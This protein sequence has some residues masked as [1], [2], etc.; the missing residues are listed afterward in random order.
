[1]AIVRKSVLGIVAACV[2]QGAAFAQATETEESK[3]INDAF[4]ALMLKDKDGA[5][6]KLE[7]VIKLNPS[8]EQAF[9]L[10]VAVEGERWREL[11]ATEGKIGEYASH[12]INLARKGRIELSRDDDAI[13]ALVR[14]RPPARVPTSPSV[15]RPP[16]S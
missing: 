6:S 10:Y 9:N 16:P 2:V 13:K 1:M 4:R 8:N 5:V 15:K 14:P 11:L 7:A 3:L 12:I